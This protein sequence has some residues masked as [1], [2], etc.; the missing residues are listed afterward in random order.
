[1]VT[2]YTT[3]LFDLAGEI[4]EKEHCRKKHRVTGD[5]SSSDENFKG[6]EEEA[7]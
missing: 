3:V 6:L 4:L 2:T 1:M 7:V 5:V